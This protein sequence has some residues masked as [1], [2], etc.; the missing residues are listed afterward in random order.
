MTG[1]WGTL[2]FLTFTA[3]LDT[4]ALSVGP[5]DTFV[6][7][8]GSNGVWSHRCGGS[9]PLSNGDPNALVLTVDPPG[10][11]NT[12]PQ[13]LNAGFYPD[14]IVGPGETTILFQMTLDDR[15]DPGNATI[16][17]A[18]SAPGY[19][20]NSCLLPT[21]PTNAL[22]ANDS[23]FDGEVE[24]AEAWIDTTGWMDSTYSVNAVG[25]D[26]LGNAPSSCLSA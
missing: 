13:H 2:D 25:E 19:W 17:G 9:P 26:S 18:P 4:S 10:T 7:A 23:A 6:H 8:Y 20:I 14:D 16:Q 21:W 1:A 3:T 15:G 12:P 5:H 11:D 24:V 22:L